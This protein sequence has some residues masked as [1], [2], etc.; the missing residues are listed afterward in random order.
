L[1]GGLASEEALR[2]W[3]SWQNLKVWWI[4]TWVAGMGGGLGSEEALKRW[5]HGI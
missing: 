5:F 4:S 2:Q 3:F 1:G